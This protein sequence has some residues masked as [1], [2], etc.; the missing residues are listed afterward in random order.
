MGDDSILTPF[1]GALQASVSVLLTIFAGVIAT[2][3]NLLSEKSSKEISKLCVQLC[4]PALLI[5]NV[6][7]Q[8]HLDTGIKYVPII[9][10]AL[11]YNISSMLL[12]WALTKAFGMPEWV[13]PAVAFNNT[14]ALPL[15]LIQSLDAT[16]ILSSL[17]SSSDVV[18]RA[19]SYL[20]VN[21][22]IGNSLTFALGPKLLNGQ[23]EDAPDADDE[24]DEQS[25][26]EIDSEVESQREE[27]EDANEDTSLLPGHV[28]RHGTRANYKVYKQGK[29]YWEKLPGWAKTTLDFMYQFL[30]APLIGAAIGMVLGLVPALHTVFFSGQQ[31]GGWANAWLT[32]PIK[33]VGE[34]FATLQVIVVGVKLSQAMLRTKRGESSGKV[35]WASML[36]ISFIRFILWPAISI[37]IIYLLA[38]KTGVLDNDPI[39]WFCM[40][41]MPTGP[42]AMKL[43][44]LADVNGAGDE[45]KMSIAKFLTISY[46]ISPLI[47]FAVVGSLKATQAAVSS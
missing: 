1:L 23:N 33:N 6:G 17:D 12:G 44:A 26:A 25:E 35:P 13:T 42:P 15:L 4:L 21:A 40:M 46:A 30:N 9:I 32:T 39:L 36:T 47:C 27:A 19:K 24:K 3:F 22:M 34:L 31:K 2:Q 14:T 28:V 7:S 8:L 41:L 38:T 11:F 10:W 29:K 5:V 16:G 18:E 45:Q 37:P 20:L 43:T